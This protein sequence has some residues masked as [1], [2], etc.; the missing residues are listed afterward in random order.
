MIIQGNTQQLIPEIL[1]SKKRLAHL[2]LIKLDSLTDTASLT[3]LV[4]KLF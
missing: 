4:E 2:K 3:D 1:T